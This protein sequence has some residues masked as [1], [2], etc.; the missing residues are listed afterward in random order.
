VDEAALT[1]IGRRER[2]EEAVSM[3]GLSKTN[4]KEA[5]LSAASS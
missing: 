2:L 1:R 3:A 5:I 4:A